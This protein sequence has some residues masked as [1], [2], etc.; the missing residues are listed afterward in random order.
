MTFKA[1]LKGREPVLYARVST[2]DQRKTLKTQIAVLEKWLK[3]NGITR[4][5]KIFQEQVSGTS[6]E[7]PQLLKA[8][9]YCVA[10]PSKTFLLVRD[11]QRISRN[12]RYGGK[13]L[14]AL[15]EADVPVVSALKNQ[16]SSTGKTIKDE[17]WLIG[18]FM[19]IGA[20][21]VDQTL[22][23][24]EAGVQEA[25][26]KGIFSG[27][28]PNLYP[29]EELN[30]LREL[31]RLLRAGIGQNDASRRLSKSTS[32]FRKRRDLLAKI[33]ERGGDELV[34][35]WLDTTD[36]I[37]TIQQGLGKSAEDKKK[38][39]AVLRM[40]S[41]FLQQPFDFPAPTDADLNEY[42]TN[43]KLYLPKRRK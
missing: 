38:E 16:I 21:E 20:Q 11:F 5:P 30:P 42:L 18:L 28:P 8:I 34:E 19:S 29:E 36:K 17:D 14:V 26:K 41:G 35:T 13:N 27:S 25:Q 23:R 31:E 32:W 15:Y 6:S 24:T 4:K 33:R 2:K 39:R 9:E 43:F 22:K 3:D 37:R 7:P 40:T 1:E 12:W 10:R